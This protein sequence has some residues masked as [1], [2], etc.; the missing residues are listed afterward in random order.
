[1]IIPDKKKAVGLILSKMHG[2]VEKQAPIASEEHMDH[3][4]LHALAEDLLMAV[5]HKSVQGVVDVFKALQEMDE[6]QDEEEEKGV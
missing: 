2:G 5:E 1:M 3:G 6:Q 4:P